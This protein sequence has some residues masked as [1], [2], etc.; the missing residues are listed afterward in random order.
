M[1]AGT[2]QKNPVLPEIVAELQD[3]PG[4]HASTVQNYR[5]GLK[6]YFPRSGMLLGALKSV[7]DAIRERADYCAGRVMAQ[8]GR[9][10]LPI[11]A[12]DRRSRTHVGTCTLLRIDGKQFLA[13]AAHVL[14]EQKHGQLWVG[15]EVALA[16]LSGRYFLTEAPDGD[17]KQDHHD[18]AVIAVGADLA[19]RLGNVRYIGPES[20]S[21]NRR[22]AEK[23]VLYLCVGYPNSKNK[24]MHATRRELNPEF[25]NHV[26]PG[27]LTHEAVGPWAKTTTDHLFVDIPKKQARNVQGQTINAVHPKGTSG[28]PV[29]YMGDFASPAT[30]A[31]DRECRPMLEA[32][33]VERYV[34][35]RALV[36]VLISTVVKA[37]QDAVKAWSNA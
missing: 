25:W 19:D 23:K 20:V 14:D 29:F 4:A 33:I 7:D 30:Y 26:G 13:T 36:A 11:Y 21:N 24:P 31:P 27:H 37:T 17:R 6:C 16:P 22:Q 28:G 15:G 1:P 32:I 18:F 2:L 35:A 10:I 3:F 8:F 5:G 34:D 12:S 9:A